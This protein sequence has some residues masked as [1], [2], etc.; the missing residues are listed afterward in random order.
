MFNFYCETSSVFEVYSWYHGHALQK[1]LLNPRRS[2]K[3]YK[4]W[5]MQKRCHNQLLNSKWGT[6]GWSGLGHQ[7]KIIFVSLRMLHGCAKFRTCM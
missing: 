3:K 2:L 6:Y 1:N 4:W 5:E 7:S